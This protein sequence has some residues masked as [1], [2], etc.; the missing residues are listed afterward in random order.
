MQNRD[1]IHLYQTSAM[2]KPWEEL[3]G[4][5]SWNSQS[6]GNTEIHK[7]AVKARAAQKPS[8]K[9]CWVRE[10]KLLPGLS[11]TCAVFITLELE[12]FNHISG[13]VA[14]SGQRIQ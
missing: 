3:L 11:L 10:E 9:V 7:C 8:D 1:L 2:G 14:G 5:F 6:W 13:L 12:S 4:T